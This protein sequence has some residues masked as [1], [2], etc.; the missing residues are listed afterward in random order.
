MKHRFESFGGIIAGEDPPFLAFVDREYMRGLGLGPSPL[1]QGP[2]GTV[3]QLQAP[4]E[5]HLALTNRCSAGCP[6]CYMD[7]GTPDPGELD[8]A[9]MRKAFA[10]LADMGA[11]HVAL[12]GGEALERPDLFE[13]AH[14]AREVGLVPNLT[15]SGRGIDRGVA[16]K[17]GVF[18]QVNV[19]MDGIGPAYGVHRGGDGFAVADRAVAALIEAG[20][21]TGINCVLGCRNFDQIPQLF[22]YAKN[23]GL[24]EIEFLRFKPAGRVRDRDRYLDQATTHA[25]NVALTPELA[26]YSQ[27]HGVTA[28]ID[29]SFIPMFCHHR[30]PLEV[31]ESLGTYGCEAGNVLWGV[32]S[33]GRV[34]G[35]SFLETTERTVTELAGDRARRQKVFHQ[36]TTWVDRAPE[37]CRSCDY[38]SVC[39]GGCRAVSLAVTGDPDAPD[40]GCPFVVEYKVA[41]D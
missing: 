37:P 35:C 14:F 6:H 16:E 10:A 9:A 31:L 25:Q 5:V 20:V 4:V 28:K 32:R 12:G 34:A 18:G 3:D 24:N 19:S 30:P 8:T 22:N 13:L 17:M 40:P 15:V 38:L 1:W 11:F 36:L 41:G 29:C 26:R 23:R 27:S 33:D 39:K 7:S 2:Q 21:P